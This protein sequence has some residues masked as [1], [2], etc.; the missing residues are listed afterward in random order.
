MNQ[1]TLKRMVNKIYQSAAFP[2]GNID[3][4]A[5]YEFE[6]IRRSLISFI[7]EQPYCAKTQ[8][9]LIDKFF[10]QPLDKRTIKKLLDEHEE[11]LIKGVMNDS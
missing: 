6:L 8:D 9:D 7:D 1:K 10:M 2:D 3:E 5:M 11:I 4:G